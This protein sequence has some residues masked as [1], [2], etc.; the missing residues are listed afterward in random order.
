MRHERQVELLERVAAAGPHLVGLHGEHS[1]VNAASVYSDPDRFDA[2]V[3][4][5]SREG[6]VFF[7]LSCEIAEPGDYLTATIGGIPI[8]VVRQSDGT[9]RAMVNACRH[10][11]APLVSD[12]TGTLGQRIVC[13]Y[14]GWTYDR[15]GSLRARPTAAGAFDDVTIGCD[16]HQVA[17][18]ERYGLIY[19]R[20]GSG[21]PIDVDEALGGAEDDLG[22][23]RLDL[24]T[25]IE[26]RSRE[27]NMNWKLAVDTFTESYHIRWLHKTTIAPY[28]TSDGV[29]FEPFGRNCASIGLRADVLDE[30][31]KPKEEWSLLPYG[32]IQYLLV[33]NAIVVHQLDH[34]EVWRLEPLDVG[35]VRAHTSIFAPKPPDES[36]RRYWIKNLDLLLDVVNNEDFPMM[37]RIY[38]TLRSGALPELVYGRNEAPLVHFHSTL[39]ELLGCGER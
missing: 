7:G 35:R 10:R 38:A 24:Y 4:V 31:A 17:V 29:I 20:A 27:W 39:N 19:V 22:A 11:G 34:V 28:F 30:L 12:R 16:L 32:T 3:R 18:A 37:E 23:F 36:A 1:M 8:L 6:P 2:E 14:H 15:D 26:T 33:P 5:L 13:G 25:H 21:E 9:L